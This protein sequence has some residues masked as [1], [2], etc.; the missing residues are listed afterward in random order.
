MKTN[1]F[2][3]LLIFFLFAGNAFTLFGQESKENEEGSGKFNADTFI[4]DHI[5]DSHEW[6]LYTR[7]DGESVAVY[8]P[9]IVY[10]KD[11]GLNIFSSEK[12]CSRS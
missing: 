3:R 1:T 6:H 8:L 7:K 5:A 10:S 11:K 2:I 4:F 12:V 9:V